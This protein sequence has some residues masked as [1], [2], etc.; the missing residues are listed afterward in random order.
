MPELGERHARQAIPVGWSPYEGGFPGGEHV[1]S[2]PW[3]N[4]R[5]YVAPVW[6]EAA[7]GGGSP[8]S[9]SSF[10]GSQHG[11]ALRTS[12]WKRSPIRRYNE[13]SQDTVVVFLRD[14]VI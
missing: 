10:Q 11:Y 9:P 14:S 1:P 13:L 7:S 8:D 6:F 5:E 4:G 3:P 2:L 12:K